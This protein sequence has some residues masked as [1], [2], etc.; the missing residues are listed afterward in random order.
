[1]PERD[2][3]EWRPLRDAP[4]IIGEASSWLGAAS[5]S[6]RSALRAALAS[7]MVL[8]RGSCLTD[9]L[10]QPIQQRLSNAAKLDAVPELNEVTLGAGPDRVVFWNV[11][12]D[13]LTLFGYVRAY[14]APRATPGEQSASDESQASHANPL[15]LRRS[16]PP[17]RREEII[18]VLEEMRSEHWLFSAIK[19]D[20]AEVRRRVESPDD[21]G[22]SVQTFARFRTAWLRGE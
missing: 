8:V 15:P 1:M 11:E 6:G 20:H 2:I 13:R 4:A 17:S 14:L 10:V 12:I 18:R 9:H 3:P 19:T 5:H 22:L 7:G 16:G 21:R